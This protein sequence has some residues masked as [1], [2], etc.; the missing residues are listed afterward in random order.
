MIK[1]PG[2][3]L[4]GSKKHQVHIIVSAYR[5]TLF[6]EVQIKNGLFV[7]LCTASTRTQDNRL[8]SHAVISTSFVYA[9]FFQD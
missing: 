7:L 1:L 2:L 8:N 5:F 9:G 6:Y 3:I 4:L